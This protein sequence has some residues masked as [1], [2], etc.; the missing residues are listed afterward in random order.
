MAARNVDYVTFNVL[1]DDLVFP[2][3]QTS[4]GILGGGGPQTAFGMRLWNDKV[5]LVGG[6][7][8]DFPSQAEEWLHKSGIDCQGLRRSDLP[9]ARAWQVTEAR[10]LRTQVWRV[11]PEVIRSQLQR[12]LE[13]L[14]QIYR[15]ARGY[16]LGVHPLSA[17]YDFIAGLVALGGVVSV[18]SFCPAV[19]QPDRD[20][21]R[22]LLNAADIFSLN[23]H[24]AI[25]LV[26]EGQ[27]QEL[28]LRLLDAGARLLCLRLGAAGA[29]LA[30]SVTQQ[31]FH[32]PAW[33][34]KV[35]DAVGAGNAF[36]GGFLV[37]WCETGDLQTAGLY[38]SVSASFLVEQIGLP[39]FS[40]RL[41]QEAQHRLE[42]LRPGVK[43]VN[44]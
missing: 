12:R 43:P 3:G 38:A 21:L 9:T 25:S 7:G 24:E 14:P 5:G 35:M 10:G 17:D 26:G 13:H 34:V 33:T 32:I 2:D 30:D 20:V 18:E 42:G 23:E 16:H 29:L 4:M 40:S 28:V 44:L 39:E 6:L 22:R 15:Q 31:A 37:G 19:K 11:G 36:C 27:P 1:L 8:P 41:V